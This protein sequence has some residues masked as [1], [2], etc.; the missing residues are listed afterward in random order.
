MIIKIEDDRSLREAVERSAEIIRNGGIVAGP[1]ETL[2]GLSADAR[3]PESLDRLYGIKGREAGKAVSVML[4]SVQALKDAFPVM[5]EEA[6]KLADQF[7]PGPL[8]LV[9]S[10]PIGFTAI[11][12]ETIGIRVPDNDFCRLLAEAFG[13]PVTT[14]SA[15]PSGKKP[16]MDAKK[17]WDYFE[18]QVDLLV[19]G[20]ELAKSDGST[21]VDVT[22]EEVKI[23][24]KGA[25]DKLKIMETVS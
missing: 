8:T 20:G 17:V 13:G 6:K 4:P 11:D 15:N 3:R 1:T 19:D 12:L 21:V 18:H 24:R 22:S 5:P 7:M 2:Y 25:I 9:L 14:T 10:Q 16:A 23:I